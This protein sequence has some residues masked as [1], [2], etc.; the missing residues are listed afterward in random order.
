MSTSA[1]NTALSGLRAAQKALDVTASNVANAG[2]EG[3]TKKSLPVS[4]Q[5]A[6]GVGIGVRY[7]EVQRYVDQY[8]QRDYRTQLGVQSYYTTRESYLSR[9][10]ALHGA[11]DDENNISAQL[12]KLQ[13]GFVSL[14]GSPDSAAIQSGILAQAG[15]VAKTMN[16]LSEQLLTARNQAEMALKGEVDSL[17]TTLQQIATLNN[18]I[19]TVNNVTQSVAYLEDQ[20]DM[21]VKQVAE[22]LDISYYIDGSNVLVLQTKGGAVLADHQAREVQFDGGALTYTSA[23]PETLSGVVLLADQS[24]SVDLAATNAGGK[25]GALIELRDKDIPTQQA[26][27]DELAHKLMLRF[28]QQ[29][30][31][32]FTDGTG[33]IPGNSANQYV[34]LAHQIRVNQSVLNDMTLLQKGTSGPAISAGSNEVINRIVDF[35]FGRYQDASNTPHTAFNTTGHGVNYAISFSVL[36]DPNASLLQ[37]SNAMLD[38]QASVYNSVKS[39]MEN[40]SQYTSEVQKRLL[41]G[42]AVNTDEEM[43]RMIEFQKAYSANAKV[44]SALDELFRDLLN[45]I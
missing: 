13:Q 34:G 39:S 16:H 25:I 37:F 29:G 11:T 5:V 26:Q 7:G 24:G 40:E 41:E 38:T 43:G 21:L 31:R 33:A 44:I 3:Y 6:G 36:N 8:I 30:L 23:Y 15:T 10:L 20:R 32:L 27:L 9:I 1:I 17:N 12:A 28:D 2:V 19:Q 4:S 14:S 35:T 18:K 42:S 45:A 22:Q